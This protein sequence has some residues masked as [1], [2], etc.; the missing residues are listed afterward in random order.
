MALNLSKQDAIPTYQIGSDGSVV[1]TIGAVPVTSLGVAVTGSPFS[2]PAAGFSNPM[3]LAAN[4]AD[5]TGFDISDCA[6]FSVIYFG[7]YASY[8]IAVEQTGDT[9]GASGWGSVALG[10]NYTLS[11]GVNLAGSS[12]QS[13]TN[14]ASGAMIGYFKVGMRA[15]I[16]V[17]ALGSG[18]LQAYVIKHGS[19]FPVHL[20]NATVTGSAANDAAISGAGNPVPVAL[21]ATTAGAVLAAVQA[22]DVVYPAGDVNGFTITTRQYSK[23]NIATATTTQVLSGV[24]VLHSVNINKG[25]AASTV[26]IYD[27]TSGTTNPIAVIDSALSNSFIYDAVIATGIRVVTSG[28]TDVTISYKAG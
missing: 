27:A 22:G 7:T 14:A 23:T 19:A 4:S 24:G 9:T 11:S 20:L 3:Y 15:R 25:V 18:T 17:T 10:E 28:A 1:D 16:K 2:L 26:S 12:A 5:S 6:W 13:G 8:S 21:R